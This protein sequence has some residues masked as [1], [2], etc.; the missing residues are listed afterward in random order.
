MQALKILKNLENCVGHIEV[1]EKNNQYYCLEI[2]IRPPGAL[3]IDLVE[4]DY[5]INLEQTHYKIQIEKSRKVRIGK[6]H[7]TSFWLWY[8]KPK[9]NVNESWLK[10]MRQYQETCKI[11]Y[12]EDYCFCGPKFLGDRF[13]EVRMSSKRGYEKTLQICNELKAKYD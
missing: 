7:K 13:Y 8:P 5:G 4:E 2:A 11:Y 10:D 1:F 3:F 6:Q 9:G 12:T